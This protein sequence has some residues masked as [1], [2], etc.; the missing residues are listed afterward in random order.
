MYFSLPALEIM[1]P[2]AREQMSLKLDD[3][4]AHFTYNVRQYLDTCFLDTSIG[5]SD[6]QHLFD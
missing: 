3:A 5:R 6:P 2:V 1:F 4:P